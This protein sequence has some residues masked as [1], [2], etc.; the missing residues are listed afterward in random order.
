ML[1]YVD[2]HA[3]RIE[4]DVDQV[5]QALLVTLDAAFSRRGAP[6]YARAVGCADRDARGPRPLALGSTLPGFHV[7]SAEPARTL[8]LEGRHRFSTYA[9]T[10]R[11]HP[12]GAQETELR[13]ETRAAFPGV[14]GTVYRLLV[15]R[16]GAHLLGVRGLLASV[17]RAVEQDTSRRHG[18]RHYTT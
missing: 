5:W 9:L 4:A 7:A 12:L 3:T 15:L 13:A 10:F 16:T 17:R 8:V 14:T 18:G 6:A 2:E 11:L 1:P